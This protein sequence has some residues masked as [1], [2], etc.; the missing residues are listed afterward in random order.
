MKVQQIARF[1]WHCTIEP[2]QWMIGTLI[3][4]VVEPRKNALVILGG[5]AYGALMIW[6][7]HLAQI[8]PFG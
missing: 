7:L 2:I 4:L 3:E 5:L 1:A 8:P 6:L